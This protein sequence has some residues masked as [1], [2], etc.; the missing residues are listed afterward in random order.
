MTVR[1]HV[2]LSTAM[3]AAALPWLKADV[4]IPFAA[5]VLV[6][7]DHYVWHAVTRRTL[8]PRAALRYFGQ[9]D[10]PQPA[11]S[12]L[13]HQPLAVGTVAIAAAATRSRTLALIL[14]GMLFHLTLD[15]V[16][17]RQTRRLRRRLTLRAREMCQACGQGPVELQLHTLRV[18]R[19]PLQR[20]SPRHYVVLCRACHRKAHDTAGSSV[21]G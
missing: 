13:L 8:S 14:G 12:R 1:E 18:S 5:S 6:D 16:H 3:A 4:W 17:E 7:A 2:T 21:T 15:V 11:Q 10:P 20:Y 19:N 9:A